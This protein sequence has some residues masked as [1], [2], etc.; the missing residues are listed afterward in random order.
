MHERVIVNKLQEV[1]CKVEGQGVAVFPFKD[2]F[3]IPVIDVQAVTRIAADVGVEEIH[4]L[5]PVCEF[6]IGQVVH[7]VDE[8]EGEFLVQGV[9][10]RFADIERIGPLDDAVLAGALRLFGLFGLYRRRA[11]QDQHKC[12][13]HGKP[14]VSVVVFHVLGDPPVFEF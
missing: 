14:A 10:R 12:Q 3:F 6:H 2:Y 11:G 7:S 4:Q 1:V 9:V 5:C 8:V 13:Q